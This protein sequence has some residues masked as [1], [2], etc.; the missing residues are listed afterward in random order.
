MT[1]EVIEY[2]KDGNETQTKKFSYV[3]DAVT[4]CELQSGKR[5]KHWGETEMGYQLMAMDEIDHLADTG[6]FPDRWYQIHGIDDEGVM[7][8]L[9]EGDQGK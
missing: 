3:E 2:D 7:R 1:V 8:P 9:E 6:E 4:W 5:Y